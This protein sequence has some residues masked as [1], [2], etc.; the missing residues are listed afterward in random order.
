MLTSS[1][2]DFDPK[3]TYMARELRPKTFG[4]CP[5]TNGFATSRA[6]SMKRSTTGLTVRF[7]RVAMA[8]VHGRTGNLTGS[9]FSAQKRA[10]DLG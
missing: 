7:F 1:S 6:H 2:S 8:T 10:T 5:F 3:L 4:A 9:T